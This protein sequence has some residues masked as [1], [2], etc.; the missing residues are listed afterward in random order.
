M[1]SGRAGGTGRAFSAGSIEADSRRAV[2]LG[3]IDPARSRRRGRRSAALAT[4]DAVAVGTADGAVRSFDPDSLAE[5]WRAGGGDGSV[6]AL[7]ATSDLLVAGERGPAGAVRA[8]DR[9]SGDL[10][11]RRDARED[12]GPARKPSRFFLPFVAAVETAPAP[13]GGGE[14]VYV[15]ARRYER[16]GEARSF[17]SAVYAFAPTGEELW[18]YE[19]DASPVALAADADRVAVGF[20]RCPGDHRRGLVVLRAATGAERTSWDPDAGGERRVGDVALAGD[21]YAVASHADYRGY[22]LGGDCEER[23]R[24]DLA[25]PVERGGDVVYAYPNHVRVADAG[26]AFVTGSTYPEEGRRTEA[27]H[28]REHAVIAR[29]PDG[30]RRRVPVGG[31]VAGIGADGDLLATPSA[32]NFRDRTPATHGLRA[33]DVAD[34]SAGGFGTDGVATAAALAGGTVAVVEEPVVYHDEGTVRGAYRLHVADLG[35]SGD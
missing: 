9:A 8:Y 11:W 15:A 10:A 13:D 21:G 29:T 30:E 33:V 14:R 34:G 25:R 2:G 6:V 31:F 17:A 28:P 22:R 32:Q 23:W 27:R 12:L 3:E 19:T 26:V 16:A 4:G 24:V 35:A 1:G 5:R 20:N 7:A 18:R